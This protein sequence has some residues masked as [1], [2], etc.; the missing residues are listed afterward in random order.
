MELWTF[1]HAV[2]LLPSVALMI[3]LSA[4][5]RHF[6][7]NKPMKIRMIPFQILSGVLVAIEIG[8]QVVSFCRGYD[9]YHIPLHFCSLFIFMLPLMS[10]YRGK[11]QNAIRGITTGLCASVFLLMMI[12]PCLIYSAGNIRDFF[13]GYMDFHTVLFHNIVVFAFILILALNLYEP[14]GR[15]DQKNLAI[16][17]LCFCGISAIMAQ[18]LKTNYNNFYKCN[19]PP[20]ETLRQSVQGVI[21]YAGAQVLYVL[22]VTVVQ[23]IFV[24]LSLL[25]YKFLHRRICKNKVT[26]L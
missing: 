22:I 10:L 14:K 23:S 21:G 15:G 6:L 4:L 19:V 25:F 24:Q 2:T 5:L 9:L 3:V 17:Y 16:F 7:I 8:K 26:H 18:V 12:Y 11:Y 20:L 1:E 13:T